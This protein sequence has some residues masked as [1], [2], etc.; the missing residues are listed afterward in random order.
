MTIG[1]LL[2]QI[3]RDIRRR[4]RILISQKY[5]RMLFPYVLL[6]AAKD[7]KDI[8]ITSFRT[9]LRDF[10]P[11]LAEKISFGGLNMAYM[12]QM[13]LDTSKTITLEDLLTFINKFLTLQLEDYYTWS[14]DLSVV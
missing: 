8:Y 9:Y 12:L 14:G 3:E 11:R 1:V 2:D 6:G 10:S 4:L 13:H 5:G 7:I